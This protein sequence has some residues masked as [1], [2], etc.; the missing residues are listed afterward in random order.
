MKKLVALSVIA[1]VL[2]A[3]CQFA[4]KQQDI[5]ETSLL[6]YKDVATDGIGDWRIPKTVADQVMSSKSCS[7]LMQKNAASVELP[8]TLNQKYCKVIQQKDG[9]SIIAIGFGYR[10]ESLPYLTAWTISLRETGFAIQEH[11]EARAKL[12]AINKEAREHASATDVDIGTEAFS[13]AVSV[14]Q[15]ELSSKL[16]ASSGEIEHIFSGMNQ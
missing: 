9:V 11:V 10:Y 16:E 2:G 15:Q 8:L 13:R 1:V 7:P 4:S 14:I 3:G 6:P 12:Q 5:N